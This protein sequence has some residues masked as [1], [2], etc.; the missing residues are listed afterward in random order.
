MELTDYPNIFKRILSNGISNFFK[1]K[2]N[3]Y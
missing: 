2:C 3:R 1:E